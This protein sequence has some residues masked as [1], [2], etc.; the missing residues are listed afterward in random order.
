[1]ARL[2]LTDASPLI[3]LTRV[4]GL[5]WLQPLFG[6]VK[7]PSEVYIEVLT[8]RRLPGE[9]AIQAAFKEGWLE[10]IA[11]TPTRVGEQ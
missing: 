6:C 3:G 1:M 11:S 8:Q 7:M 4:D 2:I 5:G 10:A 9:Q